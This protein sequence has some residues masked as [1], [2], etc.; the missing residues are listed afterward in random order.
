M[1]DPVAVRRPIPLT[2]Q[3][4]ML[5]ALMFGAVA[6]QAGQRFDTAAAV[7]TIH[8]FQSLCRRENGVLWGRSLCGPFIAIDP[9]SGTAAASDSPGAPGFRRVGD[10]A[11]GPIPEGVPFA[12]TAFDWQGARWL[13]LL[14]PV[15]G[16]SYHRAAVLLHEA[17][18]RIQPALGLNRPDAM[19]PHLD[20][21]D[22]RV[23]LRLELRAL[24][25][26]IAGSGAA[27]R[28]TLG[29]A[30]LFRARRYQRYPEAREREELLEISEGL[31]EYTGMA[32]ARRLLG[33]PIAVVVEDLTGFEKRRSFVR[34][35]GYGT[36]PA[37]G[38][39]LDR[40]RPGWRRQVATEGF[41]AQLARVA[42]ALPPSDRISLRADA[43]AVRYGNHEIAAE[44]DA[45][46]VERN[47]RIA[48]Y[49]GLFIDGPA[50]I[51]PAT[52]ANRSFNPNTLFPLPGGGTVYPTGE[53]T[54]PWGVLEISD[55][56]ALLSDDLSSLRV[57]A[58]IR[59][60]A[61]S[62]IGE[63]WRLRLNPGWAIKPGTKP[64]ESV[65]AESP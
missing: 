13:V 54:A 60:T 16:D 34:S 52:G 45:R 43:R 27:A 64:G 24:G 28:Q 21:R 1:E 4:I 55:H 10:V 37:M 22:G 30:V 46:A 23:W 29:D 49:R 15:P 51:I 53:F 14:L 40:Y 61:D 50:L 5:L 7:A 2:T 48:E 17:F 18:H 6:A 9:Q 19:N 63:G 33:T 35:L 38:S 25:R 39:L 57:T 3:S 11:I 58:P 44:E 42:P 59:T 20:E 32:A 47:R 56:G 36:G 62:A 12:N 41:A 8:E 26:A 31:A 65:L